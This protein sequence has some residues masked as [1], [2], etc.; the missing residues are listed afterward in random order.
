MSCGSNLA[1]APVGWV[2]DRFLQSNTEQSSHFKT[3]ISIFLPSCSAAFNPI[4]G[5]AARTHHD[6]V[7][8]SLACYVIPLVI[9]PTPTSPHLAPPPFWNKPLTAFGVRR[10][11]GGKLLVCRQLLGGWWGMCLCV[12]LDKSVLSVGGVKPMPTQ[13]QRQR[14][15]DWW[16]QPRHQMT[17]SSGF[18]VAVIFADRTDGV[19]VVVLHPDELS[20][21]TF[22]TRKLPERRILPSHRA[23]KNPCFQCFNTPY[24]WQPQPVRRERKLWAHY[25]KIKIKK[26]FEKGLRIVN[27]FHP[28]QWMEEEPEA[29]CRVFVCTFKRSVPCAGATPSGGAAGLMNGNVCRKDW[30]WL[31]RH[32]RPRDR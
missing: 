15:R 10:C 18:G 7:H 24:L 19:R 22:R 30:E 26:S 1:A 16:L 11:E 21:H 27:M 4:L 14:E 25:K 31:D 2:M 20:R 9:Q 6:Y 17:D 23:Q 32:T 12:V 3:T 5:G 8:I 13:G 29:A 28:R